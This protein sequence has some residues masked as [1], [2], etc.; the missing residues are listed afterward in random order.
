MKKLF[1][2]LVCALFALTSFSQK[3]IKVERMTTTEYDRYKQEWVDKEVTYPTSI[4]VMIKGSEVIIT[5]SYEQRVY[6]YG[7]PEKSTYPTHS[8]YL[9][10]ALDK[11]G[12]RCTFIMKIFNSGEVVY[13]FLYNGIGIEYLMDM[14]SN[15]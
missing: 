2:L 5:S 10:K 3:F 13:M 6:T 11:S 9:W 14:S 7:T 1:L 12:T 4:Y 8:A 15:N